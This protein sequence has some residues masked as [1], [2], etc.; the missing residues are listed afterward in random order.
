MQNTA[1]LQ[2]DKVIFDD[3]EVSLLLS[4]KTGEVMKVKGKDFENLDKLVM[5]MQNEHMDRVLMWGNRTKT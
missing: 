4:P 3:E 1:T 5:R 2:Q